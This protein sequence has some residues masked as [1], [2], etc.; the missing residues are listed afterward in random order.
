MPLSLSLL[1]VDSDLAVARLHAGAGL[2]WWASASG[3]LSVTRTPEETSVVCEADRVPE[4][5]RAERGF[6][7]LRVEGTIPFSVHGVLA[8]I[9]TPLADARIPIFVVSTFDTDYVLVR[10]AQVGDAVAVL[11]AAGHVV[12]A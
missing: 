8:A 9:S 4:G 12:N 7:A 3:F 11:R 5:V 6:R 10:E 1:L 2:P